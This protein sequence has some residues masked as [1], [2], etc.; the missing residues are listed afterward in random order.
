MRE[1]ETVF[2]I[3]DTRFVRRCQACG[4]EKSPLLMQIGFGESRTIV[5]IIGLCQDCTCR[6]PELEDILTGQG[7]NAASIRIERL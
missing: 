1:N 6:S 7:V 3:R 4:R 2:L 5:C